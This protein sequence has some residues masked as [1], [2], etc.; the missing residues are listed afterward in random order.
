[1]VSNMYPKWFSEECI[2]NLYKKYTRATETIEVCYGFSKVDAVQLFRTDQERYARFR[3]VVKKVD[4]WEKT[5]K[6]Q[7][8]DKQYYSAVRNML[9]KRPV[10]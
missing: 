7:T 4:S 5:R 6:Y 3:R 2:N 9:R 1:M 10:K 8:N